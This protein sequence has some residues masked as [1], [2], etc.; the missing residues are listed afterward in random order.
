MA[1]D[2][3]SSTERNLCIG[4]VY[5]AAFNVERPNR[6]LSDFYLINI[7]QPEALCDTCRW[8]QRY[9]EKSVNSAWP[10]PPMSRSSE[11]PQASYLTHTVLPL[12]LCSIHPFEEVIAMS[13]YSFILDI[14]SLF[15]INWRE[16]WESQTTFLGG[17]GRDK[18]VDFSLF[19]LVC[20][21]LLCWL[22]NPCNNLLERR[23]GTGLASLHFCNLDDNGCIRSI[24]NVVV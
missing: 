16:L 24:P 10:S 12:F 1:K 20:K 22:Y 23:S 4:A 14:N 15:S 3:F 21:F 11:V 5:W 13:S 9:C 19:S 8:H 17:W 18:V 2:F 6:V 7:T